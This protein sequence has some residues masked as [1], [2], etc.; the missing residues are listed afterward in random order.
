M[1]IKGI[2]K[3]I[4]YGCWSDDKGNDKNGYIF[5][6]KSKINGFVIEKKTKSGIIFEENMDKILN[7]EIEFICDNFGYSVRLTKQTIDKLK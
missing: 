4:D 6:L 1:K 5:Y 7:N 3:K 2:V